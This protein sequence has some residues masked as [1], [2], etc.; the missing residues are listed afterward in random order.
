MLR[1]VIWRRSHWKK[2]LFIDELLFWPINWTHSCATARFVR[3]TTA[4]YRHY[5]AISSSAGVSEF[6]IATLCD[7]EGPT[8][9][10]TKEKTQDRVL[11]Y[12]ASAFFSPPLV[13]LCWSVVSSSELW[14]LNFWSYSPPDSGRS[15]ATSSIGNSRRQLSSPSASPHFL[16]MDSG[17]DLLCP[18]LRCTRWN[19]RPCMD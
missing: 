14:S 10:Y 5:I 18:A 2:Y 9:E 7:D 11:S 6:L 1:N 12:S 4:K 3:G 17:A 15:N 16:L 19:C 13:N 8:E